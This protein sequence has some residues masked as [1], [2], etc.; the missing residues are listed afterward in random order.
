[1]P[2]RVFFSV[3][4]SAPKT[5]QGVPETLWKHHK[6]KAHKILHRSYAPFFFSTPRKNIFAIEKI[7]TKKCRSKKLWSK[8]NIEKKMLN[9]KNQNLKNFHQHF[10]FRPEN[11]LDFFF[12]RKNIYFRSW[13]KKDHSFDVK[14]WELS[15]YAV[16]RAF[17][18]LLDV[19][20][21]LLA[22][23]LVWGIHL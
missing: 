7:K 22:Y 16:F 11:F 6:S 10:F 13:K 2:K 9:Q 20:W 3:S 8:K 5:Y 17:P 18:A 4:V 1:M 19:F 15:I 14:F 21:S 12:D 23:G